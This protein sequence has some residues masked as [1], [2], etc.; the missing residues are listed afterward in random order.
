[1][2]RYYHVWL[3]DSKGCKIKHIDTVKCLSKTTAEQQVFM[4]YGSAS[5]YSGW[6]RDNFRGGRDV[7]SFI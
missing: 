7:K 3:V 1:M 4:N 5:K 6:S 2:F